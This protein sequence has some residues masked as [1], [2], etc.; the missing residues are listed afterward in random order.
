MGSTREGTSD[1]TRVS[2]SLRSP[3]PTRSLPVRISRLGVA[4][5]DIPR[6]AFA[7]HL[8]RYGLDIRPIGEFLRATDVKTAM[9]RTHVLNRGGQAVRSLEDDL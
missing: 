8:F 5:P 9:T 1:S 2:N 6:Q 3:L 4:T 7:S